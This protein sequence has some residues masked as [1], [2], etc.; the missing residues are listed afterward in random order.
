MS[1]IENYRLIAGSC[2]GREHAIL[3]NAGG[4]GRRANRRLVSCGGSLSAKLRWAH[5]TRGR[6]M[7]PWQAPMLDLQRGVEGAED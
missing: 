2:I 3:D 7:D 6:E 4:R 1:L 5:G